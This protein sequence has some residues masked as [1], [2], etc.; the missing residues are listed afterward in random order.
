MPD[1]KSLGHREPADSVAG[2]ARV[3]EA[4]LQRAGAQ[5]ST[6]NASLSG[7]LPGGLAG[8]PDTPTGWD[9]I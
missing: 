5:T 4:G 6:A 3:C 9:L 2:P 8:G 1:A 7:E